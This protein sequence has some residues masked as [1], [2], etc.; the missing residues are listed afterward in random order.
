MIVVPF[1]GFRNLVHVLPLCH[2]VYFGVAST[3]ESE[4]VSVVMIFIAIWKTDIR[5]SRFFN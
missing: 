1:L 5:H 3:L 2:T 4:S